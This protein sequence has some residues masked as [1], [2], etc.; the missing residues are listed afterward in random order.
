[1]TITCVGDCG[2]DN[3][4]DLRLVRPGGITLNFAVNI[5]KEFSQSTDIEV[6]CPLGTDKEA[7][8]VEDVFTTFDLV[9]H[10]KILPGKTPVQ[11]IDHDKKGEKIFTKYEEGVLADY[12]IGKEEQEIIQRSDFVMT[13]IYTQIERF[14]NSVIKV[15]P[16]GLMA[17]DFMDLSDYN[18][19]ADIVERYIEFIDIGFFGLRSH[20]TALLKQLQILAQKYNKIFIT[21]LGAD[22]SAAYTKNKAYTAAAAPVKR[23]VDTTGA[24]DAF[25][26]K[27]VKEYLKTNDI[28]KSLEAGNKRAAKIIRQV[29]SF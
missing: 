18:K 29:G 13:V 14:F 12:T 2:V 16:K 24:G 11:Y 27:F 23:I 22:G 19:K 26:A 17:V 6:I 5:R 4:T 15:D 1:M 25:A 10:A 21:T 8:V 28:Q 20:D 3:Y 9:S 7:K